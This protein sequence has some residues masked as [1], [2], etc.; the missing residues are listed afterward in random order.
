M[1]EAGENVGDVCAMEDG[2]ECRQEGDEDG[3]MPGD[4]NEAGSVKCDEVGKDGCSR[5]E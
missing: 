2:F 3:G 5:S 1:G 4:R